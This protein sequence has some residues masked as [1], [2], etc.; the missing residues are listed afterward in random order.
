MLKKEVNRSNGAD[1]GRWTGLTMP[2]HR[3]WGQF[4][5]ELLNREHNLPALL[6]KVLLKNNFF[7]PPIPAHQSGHRRN[8]LAR[9]TVA[10][11]A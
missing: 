2:N 3:V 11:G 9:A 10:A 4:H 6:A 8:S 1:Q 5:G 7:S